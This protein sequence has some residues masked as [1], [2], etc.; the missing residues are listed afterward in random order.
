MKYIFLD[1]D[2]VLNNSRTIA[3]SPNGYVGVSS[4]LVK[5]LAKI[6]KK[7]N[8]QIVL[9][10]TWK[11]DTGDDFRYLSRKLMQSG[12][13][14]VGRTKDPISDSCYRGQGI[15]AYMAKHPCDEYVILD[16]LL[17]DYKKVGILNH[18]VKTNPIEGLTNS[19]VNKAVDILFGQLVEI[20]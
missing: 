8:A 1:V 2:G 18:V 15:L 9:T 11:D 13:Y 16:D 19:D 5:R 7:T 12:L 17:F 20:S 6:V 3:K 4:S 10:S 14:L